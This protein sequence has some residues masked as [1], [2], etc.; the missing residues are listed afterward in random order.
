MPQLRPRSDIV[1]QDGRQRIDIKWVIIPVVLLLAVLILIW[2]TTKQGI[3][4]FS[5]PK[6][7]GSCHLVQLEVKTWEE[8]AHS[9]FD[10]DVCHNDYGF[11][12]TVK[13]AASW[14]YKEA[15]AYAKIQL[16]LEVKDE[17]GSITFQPV[18]PLKD[19]VCL[20]C[21]TFNRQVSAGDLIIPHQR[22]GSKKVW[23]ITCHKGVTHG[24]MAGKSLYDR[25]EE[26]WELSTEQLLDPRTKSPS[27]GYCMNCHE[28]RKV[29]R[30]CLACHEDSK[31][32]DSHLKEEFL[33]SHGLQA[34]TQLKE[35]DDC[36]G[37]EPLTVLPQKARK[38]PVEY[39]RYNPFCKSC[40]GQKPPSH[41]KEEWMFT[42][43][44]GKSTEGCF[45]CHNNTPTQG[46]PSSTKI[47]CNSCHY[48]S[49]REN[50]EWGHPFEI[51]KGL[52]GECF[53]C[54]TQ[55][56]CGSCHTSFK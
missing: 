27:M 56:T 22:H 52:E 4:F 19:D 41:M 35:C 53:S 31:K 50:W 18:T 2:F 40:H 44:R 16:G 17:T 8:S 32:P 36:H 5:G 1:T 49:H 9:R 39:A 20:E 38:D 29:N 47:N 55:R 24:V 21:H 6:T 14:G 43:G 23:C 25:N 28:R 54:H 48:Q 42:H 30:D 46:A 37:Y 10:C 13:S 34:R 7:C 26:V 12:G 15:S 11:Y 3:A 45:V 33:K 51:G